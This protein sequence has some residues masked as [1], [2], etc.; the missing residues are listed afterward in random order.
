MSI[1]FFIFILF[2]I[3]LPLIGCINYSVNYGSGLKK[4][5]RIPKPFLRTGNKLQNEDI[6]EFTMQD[7]AEFKNLKRI[8]LGATAAE[9]DFIDSLAD[10]NEYVQKSLRK[11][12]TYWSKQAM[13]IQKELD[14]KKINK[15]DATH[16]V[17]MKNEIIAQLIK[18]RDLATRNAL[19]EIERIY[20]AELREALE[21]KSRHKVVLDEKDTADLNRLFKKQEKKKAEKNK[22]NDAIYNRHKPKNLSLYLRKS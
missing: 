21:I 1:E 18:E 5:D 19:D 10:K 2:F 4:V 12:E 16:Q 20:Q 17:D 14:T 13:Q 3:V 7:A 6:I 11:G 22:Y 15:H 9:L 8:H